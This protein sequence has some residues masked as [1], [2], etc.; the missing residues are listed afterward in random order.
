MIIKINPREIPLIK[1]ANKLCCKPYPNHSRG[2]PNYN[3]KKECPPNLCKLEDL[4]DFNQDMFVI[5][6]EFDL[7][8]HAQKMKKMHPDWTDRQIYC[9]LYWQPKARK[10]HREELENY[11]GNKISYISNSPEAYGVNVTSLMRKLGVE[12]EWP[13]RR[14]TRIV[15][16]GGIKK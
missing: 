9:C 10:F 15:S 14:I 6:S 11:K 8:K 2:C 7:G 5:Y 16:L 12:L 13:P 1:N 4:F 3:K